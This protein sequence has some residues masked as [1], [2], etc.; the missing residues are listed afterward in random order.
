MRM[1]NRLSKLDQKGRKFLPKKRQAK[2]SIVETV[3]KEVLKFVKGLKVE[4]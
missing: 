2:A 1:T 3:K 4:A